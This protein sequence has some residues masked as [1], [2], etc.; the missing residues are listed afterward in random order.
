MFMPAAEIKAWLVQLRS[1]PGP[2]EVKFRKSNGAARTMHCAPLGSVPPTART[3]VAG[4]ISDET[5]TVVDSRVGQWRTFRT[6][7]IYT[8]H[9]PHL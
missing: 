6:D 4:N 7:S 2:F 5:W 1:T 8:I 3:W 9:R